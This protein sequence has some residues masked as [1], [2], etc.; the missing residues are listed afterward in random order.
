MAETIPLTKSVGGDYEIVVSGTYNY[1][2]QFPA[3]TYTVNSEGVRLIA[4]AKGDI[5]MFSDYAPSEWTISGITGFTTN[6]Q[7]TDEITAMANGIPNVADALFWL[8]GLISGTQLLDKS[9]NGRHFTITEKDFADG[10]MV[11]MPYKSAATISAP[12]GDATLIAADINN[13][14]YASNGT[15]NQ[16]PVISLFQDVDYEH[17]L[18]CRHFAQVI[19]AYGVETNEPRVLDIVL[20]NTVKTGGELTNCQ[21]Y[22]GVPVENT[23]TSVWLS[24]LGNDSTGNGTKA[25][26]Y[27]TLSKVRDTTKTVVYCKTGAYNYTGAVTWTGATKLNIIGIGLCTSD[28]GSNY[29]TVNRDLL[30]SG[31]SLL[32]AYAYP[33]LVTK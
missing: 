23:S 1:T 19:D 8:D 6:K 11:G 15:P 9:G 30:F 5:L 14:L 22:Y 7:V 21:T 27:R 25:T 12:V 16:I 4:R 3:F 33:Y 32:C 18:F 29:N 17:K 20:Y 2:K 13:Y 31:F 24:P 10:W 26:P 28:M